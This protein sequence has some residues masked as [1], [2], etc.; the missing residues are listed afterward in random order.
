MSR[1]FISYRPSHPVRVF[2]RL[3]D[4]FAEQNLFGL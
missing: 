3:P 2:D 4:G 1:V